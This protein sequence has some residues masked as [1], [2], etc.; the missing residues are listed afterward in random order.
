MLKPR[1]ATKEELKE[2]KAVELKCM[3][4]N[5]DIYDKVTI[6][7]FVSTA[8]IAVFDDYISDGPG[9]AGKVMVVV[10]SGGPYINSVYTWNMKTNELEKITKEEI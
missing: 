4:S 10:W 7:D 8:A 9:Y 5:P 6:A 2:L 3:T 1:K